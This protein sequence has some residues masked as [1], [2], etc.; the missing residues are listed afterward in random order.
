MREVAR[1]TRGESSVSIESI[2]TE[3]VGR[4]L[5][6]DSKR[7]KPE[8]LLDSDL[9]CDELDKI[10]MIMQIEGELDIAISDERMNSILTVADL[11][12]AA[13]R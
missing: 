3:I 7:I 1:I 9:G 12:D 11:V 13:Q 8:S 10:E 6:V 4:Q 2:I 5:G